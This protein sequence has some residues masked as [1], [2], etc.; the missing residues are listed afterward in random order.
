MKN[1]LGTKRASEEQMIVCAAIVRIRIETQWSELDAE[2]RSSGFNAS[3]FFF[4]FF[5]SY[6][7]FAFS[8]ERVENR[9]SQHTFKRVLPN[10]FQAEPNLKCNNSKEHAFSLIDKIIETNKCR[11]L[12]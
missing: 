12:A 1:R 11:T 2:L 4:A 3:K 5:T 6:F 8:D 10:A 9:T 7:A